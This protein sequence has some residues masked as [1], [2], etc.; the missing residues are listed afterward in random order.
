MPMTGPHN[1]YA[2]DMG[3]AGEPGMFETSIGIGLIRNERRTALN[4]ELQER[5]QCEVP[6][7][8]TT[9][10]CLHD[11]PTLSFQPDIGQ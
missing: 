4:S 2:V 5:V 11:S 7:H 1:C 8:V 10:D 9:L 3:T 6:R